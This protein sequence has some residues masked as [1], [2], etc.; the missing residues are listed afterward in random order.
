MSE[1][2]AL[3]RLLIILGLVVVALGVVFLLGGRLPRLPGDIVIRRDTVT[4]YLPLATSLLISVIATI[5]LRL[6]SGRR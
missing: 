5:V 1:V 2:A 6:L 4:I 3:G